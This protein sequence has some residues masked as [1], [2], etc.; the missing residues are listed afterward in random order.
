MV[1]EQRGTFQ[2]RT[3]RKKRRSPAKAAKPARPFPSPDRHTL[4]RPHLHLHRSFYHVFLLL[5]PQSTRRIV[6]L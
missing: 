3:Q 1:K 4:P 6:R 2:A 5:R